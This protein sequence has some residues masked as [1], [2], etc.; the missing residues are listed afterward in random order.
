MEKERLEYTVNRIDHYFD[1][2]NNKTAV[3]I[4]INTF[5]T[6]GVITLITQIKEMLTQQF[7][8]Q[9][10]IG[11]I[12]VLGIISLILLAWASIPYFSPNT[13]FDSLYYFASISDKKFQI[14]SEK[15][16]EQNKKGDL[17]DLR[18]QVHLMSIGL[19]KKFRKLTWVGVLLIAQF[20]LLAPL[21]Y[22]LISKLL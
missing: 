4:A 8:L 11:S 10:I 17:K 12:L 16:E 1:S 20:I 22:L 15:S 2:V 3:Y 19:T 7:W 5:L 6:G 13:K 14:F 18:S 21:T 9:F